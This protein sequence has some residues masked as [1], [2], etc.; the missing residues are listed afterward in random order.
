MAGVKA[1]L[2]LP[3]TTL[4]FAVA[5]G[6][7]RTDY[8]VSDGELNGGGLK[9]GGQSQPAVEKMVVYVCLRTFRQNSQADIL[10]K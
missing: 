5:P 2:T 7:V 4:H 3:V 6:S 9:H 8:I 1:F 10:L